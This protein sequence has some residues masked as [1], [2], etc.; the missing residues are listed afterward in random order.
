MASL[1]DI[2]EEIDKNEDIF[3]CGCKRIGY[4]SQKHLTMIIENEKKFLR[5]DFCLVKDVF[6]ESPLKK[7]PKDEKDLKGLTFTKNIK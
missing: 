3:W 7:I 1:K 4:D 6:K 5:R 2:K